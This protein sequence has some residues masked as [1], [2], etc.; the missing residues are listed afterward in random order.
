MNVKPFPPAAEVPE[1]NS[2]GT[3]VGSML[4]TFPSLSCLTLK[5]RDKWKH[6]QRGGRF[7]CTQQIN[8]RI[9]FLHTYSCLQA[10]INLTKGARRV[11]RDT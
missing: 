6:G 2:T 5:H 10:T 3:A 7:Q 8:P 1:Q 11:S 4:H 9:L